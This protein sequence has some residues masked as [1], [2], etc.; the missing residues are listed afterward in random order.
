MVGWMDGW[1]VQDGRRERERGANAGREQSQ[2]IDREK[3]KERKLA[4]KQKEG[5][6]RSTEGHQGRSL[7]ISI[8]FKYLLY[9]LKCVIPAGMF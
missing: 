3:K 4:K 8:F 1:M 7:I 9:A 5:K 2:E 6:V